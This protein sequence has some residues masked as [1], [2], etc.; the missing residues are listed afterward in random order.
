LVNKWIEQLGLSMNLTSQSTLAESSKT[1]KSQ[2]MT[3]YQLKETLDRENFSLMIKRISSLTYL[4]PPKTIWNLEIVNFF[5]E[6]LS[7]KS[8]SVMFFATEHQEIIELFSIQRI[9]FKTSP[10]SNNGYIQGINLKMNTNQGI[11]Q[12][13]I[14]KA[15][16]ESRHSPNHPIIEL[17]SSVK[18]NK[19]SNKGSN[20]SQRAFEMQFV[21]EDNKLANIKISLSPLSLYIDTLGICEEF[22]SLSMFKQ[23]LSYQKTEIPH[24]LVE[25]IFEKEIFE[26]TQAD[27]LKREK[28]I[29]LNKQNNKSSSKFGPFAIHNSFKLLLQ[30]EKISLHLVKD[31]IVKLLLYLILM[32]ILDVHSS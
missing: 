5:I 29:A 27:L 6:N 12:L 28:Q 31:D 8:E 17:P 15:C 24:K 1:K 18:T 19:K 22:S 30:A 9:N 3:L 14:D 21:F 2:A 10:K 32:S 13:S 16:K 26:K 23:M 25:S 11:I 20:P 4:K 7:Y